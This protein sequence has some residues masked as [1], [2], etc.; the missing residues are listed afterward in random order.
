MKKLYVF[1]HGETDW[2][3]E[4]RFQGL[5]DI[6]LNERGREQAHELSSIFE[7]IKIQTCLSSDLSRAYQTAQIALVNNNI[8]IH[9]HTEL[10]EQAGG[11]IEGMLLE[12]IQVKYGPIVWEAWLSNLEQHK[13]FS[14]DEGESNIN[15]TLK[16]RNFLNHKLSEMPFETIAISTHGGALRKILLECDNFNFRGRIGNCALFELTWHKG[17]F[18][19]NKQIFQNDSL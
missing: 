5:S 1:R 6:P 19:F 15:H 7:K 3:R 4:R 13:D 9:K 16:I 14:F 18:R 8:E 11:V 12:D 17:L 2:N 10:R